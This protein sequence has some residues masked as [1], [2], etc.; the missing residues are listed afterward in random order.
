M[1]FG[2]LG[3]TPTMKLA[4]SDFS[5]KDVP[6]THALLSYGLPTHSNSVRLSGQFFRF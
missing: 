6:D 3:Y 1:L 2:F 4:L 5:D